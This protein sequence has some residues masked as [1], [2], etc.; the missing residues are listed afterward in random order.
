[1]NFLCLIIY[2][3]RGEHGKGIITHKDKREERVTYVEGKKIDAEPVKLTQEEY[4]KLASQTTGCIS[5][6]AGTVIFLD[7][8]KYVGQ[9][10]KNKRQGKGTFYFASGAKFTGSFKNDC[11]DEGTYDFGNGYSFTGTWNADGTMRSGTYH[12]PTGTSVQLVEGKLNVLRVSDASQ[13]ATGKTSQ[14]ACKEKV[15]CP[16][17]K[18]RKG[19]IERSTQ[20]SSS[21]IGGIYSLDRYGNKTTEYGGQTINHSVDVPTFVPCK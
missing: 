18:G 2:S 16:V 14:S 11:F 15:A 17:C 8:N 6:G 1:M 13:E 21:Y 12:S 3:K 7:G 5:C 10:L 4:N 19:K 9:F 20:K